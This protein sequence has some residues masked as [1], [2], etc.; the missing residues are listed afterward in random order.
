MRIISLDV[1]SLYGYAMSKFLPTSEFEWIVL[2]MFDS[3][4]YGN[5][6]FKGRVLGV[7]F[8]YPKEFRELHNDYSSAPDKIEITKEIIKIEIKKE[9]LSIKLSKIPNCYNTSIG[10]TSIGNVASL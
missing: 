10:N 5:N 1:N 6:N 2:G 3:D 7:D 9:M 8:E 4:K